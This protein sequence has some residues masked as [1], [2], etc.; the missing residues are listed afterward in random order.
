MVFLFFLINNGILATTEVME[1]LRENDTLNFPLW[2]P[3]VN[4]YTS[5]IGMIVMLP[6]LIRFL[7]RFPVNWQAVTRS[8]G[9]YFPAS[10]IFSIGHISIMFGLRYVI[11]GFMDRQFYIGDIAF[12][13]LYEYR[14]DL[15]SFIALI[16]IIKSYDFIIARLQ[17]EANIVNNDEEEDETPQFD[18][19]LVKKL[20]KEFILKVSDI[21]WLE[22][23][24]NYV[25]LHSRGRIYPMRST[26]NGLLDKIQDK[27]FA[28][29][30]RSY[31]V[32]LECVQEITPLPG[33][34][35]E[36]ALT[37]GKNLT[38]SRRYKDQFRTQMA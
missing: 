4:E 29:I 5:A 17:G 14:K 28:R 1:E 23:S 38:L 22:S 24:G 33:G 20:G 34:D 3:F 30:H 13:F 11:F 35:S 8:I 25:N 27:G 37:N 19:L 21:E 6:L 9:I 31:G 10:L 12:E 26:L 2:Q 16:A 36:I 15:W 7:D 32:N 18:R